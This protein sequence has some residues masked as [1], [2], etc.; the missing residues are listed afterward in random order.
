MVTALI[1]VNVVVFV[2]TGFGSAGAIN[3]FGLNPV[4]VQSGQAYRLLT[5]AFLHFNIA[6][7]G[8]NM[9]TL[10]IVGTAVEALLGK[11]RFIVLY[12][13]AALG[14]SVVFYLLVPTDIWGAGASGAIFGL[15]GAYF[16]LA[17]H[18]GLNAG[19]IGLLIVM[20]LALGF[21]DP[22]IGWEAHVGGL[23]V[24]AAVAYGF[25]LSG[26]L[27]APMKVIGQVTTCVLVLAVLF[28]LLHL[29]PGHVN[30]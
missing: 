1:A 30:A 8:L 12:L 3:R 24:G 15:M 23:I 18:H 11:V 28:A 29:P 7:I 13:I 6:H 27:A 9:V 4:D 10:A 19:A 5:S 17:R 21:V 14:G 2:L 16:V 26:H 25:S 22:Q 20:N